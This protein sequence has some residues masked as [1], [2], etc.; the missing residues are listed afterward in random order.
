MKKGKFMLFSLFLSFW[1]ISQVDAANLTI[2]APSSANV[3]TNFNVAIK[4][5]GETIGSLQ[6]QIAITNAECSVQSTCN[7]GVANCNGGSCLMSF[8]LANGLGAGNN[9]VTL[10]CH[11]T[12]GTAKFS[13]S[14]VNNDAWDVEGMK[15]ISVKSASRNVTIVGTTSTS[16]KTTTQ[17]TLSKRPT[18]ARPTTTKATTTKSTKKTTTEATKKTTTSVGQTTTTLFSHEL[19]TN[20]LDNPT[21]ET[22]TTEETTT[23]TTVYVPDDL[24]LSELKIVG[25]NINFKPNLVTYNIDVEESVDELYLIATPVDEKTEIE[26]IGL[27][28]IKDK[29][30]IQIRVYNENARHEINYKINIRR[31]KIAQEHSF[32]GNILSDSYKLIILSMVGVIF[33]LIVFF[34]IKAVIKKVKYDEEIEYLDNKEPQEVIPTNE[35]ELRELFDELDKK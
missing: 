3:N 31:K 7:G 17:T 34:T 1:A 16:K 5:T 35:E 22:T 25:Y 26:G 20:V 11:S 28:D 19:T 23:T 30:F 15:Q 32:V 6:M 29:E 21:T 2:T 9:I 13:A 27:I 18:T 12:G 33:A 4:H 8:N 24:K 10:S 14:I